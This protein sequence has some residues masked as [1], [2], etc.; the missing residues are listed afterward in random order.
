MEFKEGKYYKIDPKYLNTISSSLATD[1]GTLI[2]S[3]S[4]NWLYEEG[5]LISSVS[6]SNRTTGFVSF[7]VLACN[8]DNSFIKELPEFTGFKKGYYYR[9]WR[10][11]GERHKRSVA[12][13]NFFFI[14]DWF[15]CEIALGQ[16]AKFENVNALWYWGDNGVFH[17]YYQEMSPEEYERKFLPGIIFE[18]KH[19]EL[20]LSASAICRESVLDKAIH[21][22][23]VGLPRVDFHPRS[24]FLTP[25]PS[26]I[27]SLTHAKLLF[28]DGMKMFFD[29]KEETFVKK[30]KVITLKTED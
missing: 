25:A 14:G 1:T 18:H 26:P 7:N 15:K 21:D 10:K 30:S 9:Y 16:R 13:M 4:Q 23:I 20:S 17:R 28:G 6:D 3:E 8:G 24:G 2:R 29:Q 22:G 5:H 19:Q 11:D 12:G 27:Q